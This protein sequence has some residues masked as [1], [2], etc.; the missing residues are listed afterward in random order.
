MEKDLT[1]VGSALYEKL[2]ARERSDEAKVQDFLRT[3]YWF[4][5]AGE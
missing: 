3:K 5:V 4:T 1:V 2:H